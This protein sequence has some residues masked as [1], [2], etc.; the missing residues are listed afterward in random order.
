MG[1]DI[2]SQNSD[3]RHMREDYL[4]ETFSLASTLGRGG[5]HQED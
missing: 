2:A 3:S 4:M 1:D 5:L